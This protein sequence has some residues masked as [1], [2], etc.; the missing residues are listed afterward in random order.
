MEDE[1]QAGTTRMERLGDRLNLGTVPDCRSVYRSCKTLFIRT[2]MEP[3]IEIGFIPTKKDSAFQ[4]NLPCGI[5]IN[6]L[7]FIVIPARFIVC[8]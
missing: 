7:A 8:L 3:E 6:L 5:H 1:R 2:R 4:N